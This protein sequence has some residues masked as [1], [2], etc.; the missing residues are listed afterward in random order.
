M[1]DQGVIIVGAG[2][3]GLATAACLSLHSIPYIILE[4]EDCS[5]SIWKKYAYDRLHLHLAKQFCELPHKSIPS[6]YPTY[7]SKIQFIQYLDDYTSRFRISPMYQRS[8]ELAS[9]DQVGKKWI[10]KARKVSN[11]EIVEY[12]G[13]FLVVASGEASNPYTP[14]VEGLSTFPGEVIH[15][16][17]YKNGKAYSDNKHVLVV[18]S[19]NS[20]M[21]IALDLANYGAN[22]S[23][24]VR[25][26]VHILT[27][28]MV[29]VGL[30]MFKYLRFSMVDWLMVMLSKLV[31][32]D[33]SK[34]GITRPTEG[35]FF[36]K[37][38]Y[39][40]YPIVDIGTCKKIESGEIQVLPAIASIRGNDVLFENGKSHP[41][42]TII[43][44]TGFKRST[45]KWLKGGDY[46]L[47]DDGF[48]KQSI[49]NHWKGKNGLYCVGLSRRGLYGSN[50]DAQNIADDIKSLV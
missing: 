48:P 42:D 18:G 50:V 49:P 8:V 37:A 25:S 2:P 46:L 19:G 41:F 24:V 44:C 21:E 9:Y 23:I 29:Y 33:Q 14:E 28:E 12:R 26:P 6:S 1:E 30:I 40:K 22:I 45:N 35:P 20:G 47:N 31:Y 5:A 43:F 32:G 36:M 39:G 34:Y 13:R 15:S 3:S 38:A 27:R 7:V 10:V 16:T 17:Q 11:G 4:R